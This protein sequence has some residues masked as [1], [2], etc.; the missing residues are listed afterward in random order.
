MGLVFKVRDS[1]E[2]VA[3]TDKKGIRMEMHFNI[4]QFGPMQDL[5][6]VIRMEED[7]LGISMAFVQYERS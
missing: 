1:P 3:N 7:A 6:E 5:N 2:T 4:E